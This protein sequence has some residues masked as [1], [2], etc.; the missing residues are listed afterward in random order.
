MADNTREAII[1][2]TKTTLTG[3]PPQAWQYPLGNRS[4]LEWVLDQHRKR[5]PRDPTIRE[6]FNTYCFANHKERVKDL[7]RRVCTVS[8]E[9]VRIV[10]RLNLLTSIEAEGETYPTEDERTAQPDTNQSSPCRT[11]K[12]QRPTYIRTL[13]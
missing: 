3:V 4:A 13:T 7:L 11:P 1:L 10:K 2:H 6:R 8:V 5:T 9:T 12:R